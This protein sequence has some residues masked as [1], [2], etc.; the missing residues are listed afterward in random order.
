MRKLRDLLC[1]LICVYTP[2]DR[3]WWRGYLALLPYAGDWAYRGWLKHVPEHNE[4]Q[5]RGA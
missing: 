2:I 4:F 5:R 1:N 3:L